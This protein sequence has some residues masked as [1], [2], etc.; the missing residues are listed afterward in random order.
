MQSRP[1]KQCRTNSGS[2]QGVKRYLNIYI[3]N[4]FYIYI[5]I[6]IYFYICI[7]IYIYIFPSPREGSQ[8]GRESL[9]GPPHLW[10]FDF[11]APQTCPQDL[12]SG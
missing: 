5:Y 7:Y 2:R 8:E 9:V 10:C 12:C 3:Y 6:Y 11:S 1:R 4:Y